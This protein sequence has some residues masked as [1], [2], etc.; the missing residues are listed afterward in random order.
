MRL[1]SVLIFV[2]LL[3]LA[4]Q[5]LGVAADYGVVTTEQL[6]AQLDIKADLILVDARTAEEFEQSHIPGAV[7]INEKNFDCELLN[8]PMNNTTVRLK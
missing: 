1:K 8:L 7:N 5:S 2:M 3:F 6:K 4:L